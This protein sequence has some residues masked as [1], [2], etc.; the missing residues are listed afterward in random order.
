M[1]GQAETSLMCLTQ[2]AT[3]NQR[4]ELTLWHENEGRFPVMAEITCKLEVN[5]RRQCFFVI[6]TTASI[7]CLVSNF[8]LSCY[9]QRLNATLQYVDKGSSSFLK[10]SNDRM[11]AV[12]KYCWL[13]VQRRRGCKET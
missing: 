7:R 6:I 10:W 11:F 12:V 13:L 9:L 2:L 4:Q 5:N 3:L 8:Q 1:V